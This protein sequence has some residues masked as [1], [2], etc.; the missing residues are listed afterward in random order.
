VRYGD[1]QTREFAHEHRDPR[2]A[3]DEN[4]RRRIE[5]RDRGYL[6]TY[7]AIDAVNYERADVCIRALAYAPMPP[8]LT[9]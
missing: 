1:H 3:M 2:S 4:M 9:P 5:T 8:T 7:Y 6:T